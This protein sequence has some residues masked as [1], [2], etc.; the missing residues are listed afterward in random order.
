MGD[1]I[2]CFLEPVLDALLEWLLGWLFL[3]I[4]RLIS[5]IATLL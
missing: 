5:A 4:T 1:L 2:A 3:Q